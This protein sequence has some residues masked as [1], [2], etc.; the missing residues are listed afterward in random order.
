MTHVGYLVAGWGIVAV[1]TAIYTWSV[2][3]RGRR[4][5]ARVP[6][7]RQRWME[8]DDARTIGES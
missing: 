7:D 4:L 8:S 1:T 6:A 5:A 2:L 3:H